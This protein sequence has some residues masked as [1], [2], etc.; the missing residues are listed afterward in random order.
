MNT[1]K[2]LNNSV[3]RTGKSVM[4]FQFETKMN[5]KKY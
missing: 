3:N 5:Y 4:Q 2:L 1:N